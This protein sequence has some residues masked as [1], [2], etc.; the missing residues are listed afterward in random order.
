MGW[1]IFNTEN[2]TVSLISELLYCAPA[3]RR[4]KVGQICRK[5]LYYPAAVSTH[6]MQYNTQEASN[7]VHGEKAFSFFNLC[8]YALAT[9]QAWREC[10]NVS[11]AIFV[12]VTWGS[13]WADMQAY[14]NK[15][16]LFSKPE[17]YIAWCRNFGAKSSKT[18]QKLFRFT[19]MN[20]NNNKRIIMS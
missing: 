6:N 20:N 12:H 14:K 5:A 1:T 8:G 17:Q 7:R 15:R 4:C 9:T 16:E 2:S 18:Y 3:H 19:A 10:C 11:L 13:A